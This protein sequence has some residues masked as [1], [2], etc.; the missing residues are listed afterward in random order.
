L[1]VTA[2]AILYRDYL[3]I[4]GSNVFLT[5][6]N[7]L[8]VYIPTGSDFNKV[9]NLLKEGHAIKDENSFEW[10]AL[11]KKYNLR[12][13]PGKY[14]ILNGMSNNDLVGLLR[15][16]KQEPVRLVLLNIRTPKELAVKVALQ[17][18]ADSVNLYRIMT[19]KVY[20]AQFGVTPLTVLTLFIPNTYEFFWNTSPIQ[21]MTR[22]FNEKNKFWNNDRE[23]KCRLSGLSEQKVM[24]LASIIEKETNMDDEKP[25][26][27]GVYINRLKKGWYLQA[28]PTLVYA[29]KEWRIKRV[30][31]KHKK[32]DSPYNTYLYPGLPPG[33]LCLPSISSIDAVLNY[34]H[35]SY[36]YFC[37]KEDLSGYH[38]FART[39]AE[40]N[41]NARRYQAAL[42]KLK[43][44]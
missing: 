1:Q 42:D 10:V 29:W 19:D 6:R 37:A 5:G 38:N 41:R 39:L 20:L 33:P 12:V 17:L 13:K 7:F 26:L 16:G 30:L 14:R 9:K 25:V 2:G 40:H 31:D 3:R 4:W 11:L 34:S 43:I 27:A 28:D 8:Y 35:H 21:F 15:S 36:M 32:I 18:E 23:K 44:K 24:I 22:M